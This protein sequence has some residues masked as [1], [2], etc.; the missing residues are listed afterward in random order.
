[1]YTSE[2]PHNFYW[3]YARRGIRGYVNQMR[4]WYYSEFAFFSYGN[5]ERRKHFFATN[6]TNGMQQ[7]NN[8]DTL[9]EI[10]FTENTFKYGVL[11]SFKNQPHFCVHKGFIGEC[12][13]GVK[14][15]IENRTIAK[16]NA[17]IMQIIGATLFINEAY[18]EMVVKGKLKPVYTTALT[19]CKYVYYISAE[20]FD[21][22]NYS[23]LPTFKFKTLTQQKTTYKGLA[24]AFMDDIEFINRQAL[25]IDERPVRSPYTVMQYRQIVDNNYVPPNDNINTN[26]IPGGIQIGDRAAQPLFG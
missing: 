6:R 26:I 21:V 17:P 10:F 13:V 19:V 9:K 16:M 12:N 20:K 1:M 11:F 24:Q 5:G 4:S 3:D 25:F 7:Q 8:I 15:Y 23:K 18:R 14:T 2:I 22:F